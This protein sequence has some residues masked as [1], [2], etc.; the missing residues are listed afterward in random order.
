MSFRTN[1][2]D[3]RL[4]INSAGNVGIGVVPESD[5][6]SLH[7]ALQIGFDGSLMSHSTSSGWTQLMKN[8]RYVGGGVYKYLNT[9]E[10]TRYIQKDNGTHAFEVAPSGTADAAISWTTAMTVGNNGGVS[11]GT[12]IS[13]GSGGLLV[14]NDIKTVSRFGVGSG[15]NTS[16]AAIYKVSDPDTGLYWP[17]TNIIGLTTGGSERMRIDSSGNVGIGTSS[18]TKQLDIFN[19]S[20]SWNQRASIG[21]ATEAQGTFNA[22]MYYHRGTSNDTD[23]GLKFRVHDTLCQTLRSD[24]TTELRYYPFVNYEVITGTFVNGAAT[25]TWHNIT[26]YEINNM[27]GGQGDLEVQVF[28]TSGSTSNGYNHRCRLTI[29]EMSSNSHT[30]Y[31]GSSF[32]TSHDGGGGVVGGIPCTVTHHTSAPALP[33]IRFRL[34]NNSGVD[35]GP[36]YLQVYAPMSPNANNARITIWKRKK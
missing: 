9:N 15:G 26:N 17:A 21:L 7:T 30:T 35:Y 11:I 23:R 16:T 28:W 22:E 8:S 20:Q 18:P 3:D 5:W 24:G 32:A 1:S 6:D 34:F 29:P 36:I 33:D 10:A 25:N 12:P 13:A 2:V 19:P 4:V 14:D 31:S 27:L